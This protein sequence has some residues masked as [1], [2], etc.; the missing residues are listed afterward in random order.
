MN[1]HRQLIYADNIA[2]IYHNALKG[3]ENFGCFSIA[4]ISGDLTVSKHQLS[5]TRIDRSICQLAE[6]VSSRQLKFRH[7]QTSRDYLTGDSVVVLV[8]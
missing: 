6:R 1:H 8:D 4:V 2:E 3:M 7:L 5:S